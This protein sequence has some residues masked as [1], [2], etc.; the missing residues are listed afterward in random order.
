MTEHAY[1]SATRSPLRPDLGESPLSPFSA[2][3][4]WLESGVN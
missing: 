4:G 3:S 1:W 2:I